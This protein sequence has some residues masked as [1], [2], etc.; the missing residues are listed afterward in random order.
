MHPRRTRL[1]SLRRGLVK[2][3]IQTAGTE[4]D[5]RPYRRFPISSPSARAYI[6]KGFATVAQLKVVARFIRGKIM[7]AADVLI[8]TLIDWGAD[9]VF[10]LREMGSTV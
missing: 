1:L 2:R 4:F 8:E 7:T 3:L 5:S 10:G 9:I 6:R